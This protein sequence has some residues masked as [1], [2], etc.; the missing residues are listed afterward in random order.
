MS[1]DQTTRPSTGEPAG[2]EHGFT[3]RR[4]RRTPWVLGG[5]AAAVAVAA[6][7]LLA[8]TRQETSP[9]EVAGAT[10]VVVSQEGQAAEKALVDFVGREVAP[11]YGIE[12]EFRGLADSTQLNR[13]VSEGEVAGTVY[14]HRLWLDQVLEANPDFREEAATPVYRWGFGLWSDKHRS[15]QDLPDGAK[16]SLLADPANEAQG[17]WLL[18]RAGLITLEEGVDRWRATRDDI[19]TNPKNLQFVLLD[20]GAQPLAL[21]DLDAVAGYT[22]NFTTAGIGQDKLIF[23]PTPPD[24]FAAQLTIG[25]RWKDEE[26]IRKLVAAFR[27]PAVQEFLATDPAVKGDLLPLA[28]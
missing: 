25:S 17:L 23:A 26:N 3:L 19:A 7:A 20:F 22:L 4:R 12:V 27:D 28:G 8:T 14:Q 11:R 24:E 2:H 18:E 5:A 16:V 10:L 13:A 6:A 9:N 15:P 21:R 1:T